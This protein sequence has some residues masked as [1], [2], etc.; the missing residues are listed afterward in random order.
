MVSES[1]G[2]TH[3][4]VILYFDGEVEEDG[5][6]SDRVAERGFT[7]SG[8]GFLTR[9]LTS[10]TSVTSLTIYHARRENRRSA[11]TRRLASLSLFL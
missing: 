3:F 5:A 1:V 2:K 6:V 9:F 10:F 8:A 11:Q 4:F 7:L